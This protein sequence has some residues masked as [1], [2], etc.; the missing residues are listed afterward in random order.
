MRRGN[1]V[2]RFAK[3]RGS[4]LWDVEY[5]RKY[6]SACRKLLLETGE[7]PRE[8]F[9]EQHRGGELIVGQAL[10]GSDSSPVDGI[11]LDDVTEEQLVAWNIISFL[12]G[13]ISAWSKEL[14][15]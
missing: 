15:K 6:V 11:D 9:A 5:N 1:H 14:G 4:S 10:T 13:G 8:G 12:G 3:A 7:C 2:I